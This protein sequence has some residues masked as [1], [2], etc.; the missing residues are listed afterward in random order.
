MA[1]DRT[2]V[3]VGRIIGITAL[4][5]GTLVATRFALQ[6]Y[7][8]Q[9]Y[10]G[11]GQEVSLGREPAQLREAQREA[12]ARLAGISAA[13]DAVA[14]STRHPSLTVNTLGAQDTAALQGW[15]LMPRPF[16][17]PPA[18]AAPPPAAPAP[19]VAP[20]VAPA[21]NPAA[22]AAVP[23]AA[24]QGT[25]PGANAGVITQPPPSAPAP[26]APTAPDGAH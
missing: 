21:P 6:S 18:P 7:F 24:A 26:T 1:T 23:P 25:G 4:A 2:D 20:A 19:E 17:P 5:L 12:Q 15:G 14:G 8:L 9:S 11:R 3:P 10:E 22:P 13:M 16:T